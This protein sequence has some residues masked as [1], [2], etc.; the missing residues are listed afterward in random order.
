M[1]TD[2]SIIVPLYNEEESVDALYEEV[3][4]AADGLGPRWASWELLLVDD[5]STD[6]TV[7]R[8][9]EICARDSRVGVIRF[10]RNYGQTAALQAG[11]D[12]ARGRVVITLDGDLQNDPKDFGLLLR[13]LDEGYDVVCGW[14]RDRKDKMV[15][16]RIPS[17]A[18]NWLIGRI[19]GTH[20]HDNGCTLKA[21]RADVVKRARL[22]A[23]MHRFLAP[24]MALSG[25]RTKEVVVNHRARRFGRSKYGISRIWKVFLDLLTVKMLLHFTTRPV[26]WFG[27]LAFPFFVGMLLA[28]AASVAIHLDLSQAQKYPLVFPSITILCAFAFAHLVIVGIFSELV[29][30][31]GDFRETDAVLAS[32][33]SGGSNHETGAAA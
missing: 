28:F 15:S 6:G 4:A 14:R 16:R 24:I 21:Y 3:R 18:A 26:K 11:F 27:I 29:V 2:L 22:Y 20:V 31:M 13:T 19:T 23:E 7:E 8:L 32:S 33:H 5:G 10:R 25:S 12:Q 30:R 9:R 1:T 17:M